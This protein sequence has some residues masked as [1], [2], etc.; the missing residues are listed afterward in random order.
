MSFKANLKFGGKEYRVLSVNFA[1]SRY[2]DDTGRPSSVTRGGEIQFSVESTGDTE[3]FEGMC[4]SFDAKDGS[5]V[6]LKRDQDATMKELK[7]KR[8]HITNYSESF[9]DN[10][11]MFTTFGISCDEIEMGNGKHSNEWPI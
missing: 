11:G 4:N 10:G 8:A 7:F 5:V 6:F 9:S 1:L 3:L 2:I